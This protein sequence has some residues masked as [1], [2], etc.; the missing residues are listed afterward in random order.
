MAF[1]SRTGGLLTCFE[2]FECS[3]DARQ[4]AVHDVLFRS[5][6][7]QDIYGGNSYM[8]KLPS[9]SSFSHVKVILLTL[10]IIAF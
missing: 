3:F 1:N 8:E 4:V 9:H 5:F 2:N 10:R 6:K 7:R